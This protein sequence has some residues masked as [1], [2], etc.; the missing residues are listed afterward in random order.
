MNTCGTELWVSVVI[1][2]TAHASTET[3]R[4][5][6]F[7]AGGT[8]SFVRSV[9]GTFCAVFHTGTRADGNVNF[10]R[11][12]WDQRRGTNGVCVGRMPATHVERLAMDGWPRR[13][14]I[15]GD[16]RTFAVE[17]RGG[18]YD[19][20]GARRDHVAGD[21]RGDHRSPVN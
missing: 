15:G 4:R 18:E 13:D 3:R 19:F 2:S 20:V 14:F 21:E 12:P 10:V 16:I 1:S 9:D 6:A 5:W 11:T 7:Y 8:I 17:R